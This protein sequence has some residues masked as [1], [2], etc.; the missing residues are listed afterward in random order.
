MKNLKF[1][2]QILAHDKE[3]ICI[4]VQVASGS[5]RNSVCSKL[6]GLIL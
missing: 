5:A 1:R 3:N 6:L 2:K 4:I